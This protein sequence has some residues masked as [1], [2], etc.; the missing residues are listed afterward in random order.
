M[1][2]ATGA[3]LVDRV[4]VPT[5]YPMPPQLMVDT[6]CRLVEPLPPFDRVSAGFPGMVRCGR[7]LTA[8]HFVTAEGPGTEVLPELLKAWTG[9]DL[10][11]ALSA[12]TGKP[13]KVVND[14]DMQGAAV[15]T[16]KGL[17]LVV[18]LGTGVGTALFYEGTLCP[19][20]EFA[21]H[22][23]Q[24]DQTYNQR[25]G[26]AALERIGPKKWNRRVEKAI[27]TLYN[28]FIYDHLFIG[29]GNA[30]RL[31]FTL[32]ANASVIDN[33]AGILGGIKLWERDQL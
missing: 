11:A 19:H 29:G 23:L 25:L 3:M 30:K 12:R 17:E 2:D 18:T 5:T 31:A 1:L 6:L 27:T 28:L 13:A 22:P 21:H 4:R 24:K 14:A 20:M 15:V 26:D 10:A 33:K 32:P 7:V 9:F 16:G 8:P